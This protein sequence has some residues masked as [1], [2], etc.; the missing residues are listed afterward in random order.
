[1]TRSGPRRRLAIGCAVLVVLAAT[2]V[3]GTAVYARRQLEAPATDHS[4][5]VLVE[6]HP[7]ESIEALAHDLAARGLVRSAFWFR[8][9]AT[10]RG[11]GGHLHRGD[12]LL[13]SGMGASAIVAHL[14]G[15]PDALP[16]RLVLPE[17][18]TATQM[19]EIVAT[20]THISAAAYLREVRDGRFDFPFLAWRPSGTSLEGFLFPDTYDV[21]P[22]ATAHQLVEM[23]LQ[24][25]ARKALPHLVAPSG[26][27]GPYQLLIVAS[28]VQSEARFAS[29]Q[30]LVASVIA[31]RLVAQMP[32]DIDSAVMYGVGRPGQVPSA[33]D[34][35]TDTPYN[36]YVHSGL[37]PT[38]ISN[39]GVASIDAAVHPA[40]T[41][42][43]YFVSDGCGH[44][45]YSVTEAEHEQQV[46]RYLG[47]PCGP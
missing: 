24:A 44:N 35:K 22:G 7:G 12:Y 19:A 10:L 14:E 36:T 25:F 3:A 37:P 45:H 28:L 31:N 8:W 18:L 47:K 16:S 13:D 4:H 33:A 9:Y 27:L 11:L 38:P 6:V 21:P 26:R 1:M 42:Y 40:A 2:G 15:P 20:Q 32:L 46:A 23:Q 17:G 5:Q 39:P 30:P 41:A 29:D 34:L 43:R